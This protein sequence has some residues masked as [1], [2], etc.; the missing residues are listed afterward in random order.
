MLDNCFLNTSKVTTGLTDCH[1]LILS[2]LKV[3]LRSEIKRRT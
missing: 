2:C 3:T 1:K